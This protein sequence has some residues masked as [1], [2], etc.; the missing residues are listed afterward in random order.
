[1]GKETALAAAVVM[2]ASMIWIACRNL[3][4]NQFCGSTGNLGTPVGNVGQNNPSATRL[5]PS[6]SFAACSGMLI[7]YNSFNT[8]Q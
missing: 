1:M 7:P 8:P 5:V 3:S 6:V 2:L 4:G